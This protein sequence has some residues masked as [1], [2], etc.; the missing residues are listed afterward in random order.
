[1]SGG[2]GATTPRQKRHAAADG[3]DEEASRP[4]MRYAATRLEAYFNSRV[5]SDCTLVLCLQGDGTSPAHRP[6]PA[7]ALVLCA[8]SNHFAVS[9]R[10]R[11]PQASPPS[12]PG[13]TPST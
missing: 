9:A 8:N 6:I 4:R 11:V 2:A 5:H 12:S 13:V 7:H 3:A 1:M 10:R